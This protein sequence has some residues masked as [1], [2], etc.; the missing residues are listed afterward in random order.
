MIRVSARRSPGLFSRDA[1]GLLRECPDHQP[2]PAELA[3]LIAR[4]AASVLPRHES[5]GAF[6]VS[7][8]NA[9]RLHPSNRPQ[10]L[11]LLAFGKIENGFT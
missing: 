6:L 2:K 9:R 1:R 5:A 11:R 8:A 3:A 7:F 10:L 4:S